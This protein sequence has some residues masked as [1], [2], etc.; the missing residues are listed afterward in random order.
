MIQLKSS[1]R[2]NILNLRKVGTAFMLVLLAGL[3]IPSA[4]PAKELARRLGVGVKNNP[5]LDMG[6]LTATYYP[7]SDIALVGAIGIDTQKDDSKF[8]LN[9]ALRRIIFKE[10]NL[11]FYL[12]GRAGLINYESGG[13]KKSG[14]DISGLFGAEFFL[15]GLDSL[16]LTFEGGVGVVSTDKVRFKT[17]AQVP[18]TAGVVFYF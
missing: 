14:F 10:N 8:S 13:D 9:A 5:H 16:G 1:H 12:G 17:I 11:N 6:E 4:S 2:K 3:I 18:F 15:P 7:Q